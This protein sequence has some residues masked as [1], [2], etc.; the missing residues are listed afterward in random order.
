MKN[1]VGR[2]HYGPEPHFGAGPEAMHSLIHQAMVGKTIAKV[3]LGDAPPVKSIAA[4]E[5]F[6][7]EYLI[8]EFADGTLYGIEVAA[9][10]SFS[11][12]VSPEK[13]LRAAGKR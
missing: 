4:N 1:D 8:F 2:Y 12:V 7:G 11:Q 9:G 13:Y 10:N 5:Q 3:F 6:R